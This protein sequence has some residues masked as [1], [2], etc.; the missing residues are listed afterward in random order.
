MF[1]CV[2]ADSDPKLYASLVKS[3]PRCKIPLFIYRGAGWVRGAGLQKAWPH[4]RV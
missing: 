2:E 3:S 4:L 1:K